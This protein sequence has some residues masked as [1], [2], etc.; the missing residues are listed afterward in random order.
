MT[1]EWEK[2]QTCFIAVTN[3]LTLNKVV[4]LRQ[5]QITFQEPTESLASRGGEKRRHERRSRGAVHGHQGLQTHAARLHRRPT[6]RNQR[7]Q[8]KNHPKIAKW[9]TE[10]RQFHGPGT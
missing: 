9:G 8:K 3:I 5:G 2:K 7:H 10:R 1:G 6:D 4:T